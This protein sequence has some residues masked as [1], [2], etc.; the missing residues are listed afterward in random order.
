MLETTI[1]DLS[2]EAASGRL[3]LRVEGHQGTLWEQDYDLDEIDPGDFVEYHLHDIHRFQ[4]EFD[5]GS[6]HADDIAVLLMRDGLPAGALIGVPVVLVLIQ[7]DL[8]T[9]LAITFGGVVIMFLAGLPTRWFAAAGG[10][11]EGIGF[12]VS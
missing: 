4:P 11:A 2:P 3:G 10:S 6:L 8:G 9:A 7:P 5:P 1:Y 12:W